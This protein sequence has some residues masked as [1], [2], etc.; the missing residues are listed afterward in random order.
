MNN[1]IQ[2]KR[3]LNTGGALAGAPSSLSG[4]EIAFNEVDNVLYYG[5][6][7]GTVNGNGNPGTI[8]GIAGPGLFVDR[9][10]NQTIGG[11]KTFTNT[12]S[13]LGNVEVD[14]NVDALTLSITGTQIVDSNRKGYFTDLDA[15]GNVTVTGNLTVLGSTTTLDTETQQTSAVT[16]TNAGSTVALTV[17][18]TGNMPVAHFKDDNATALFIDGSSTAPGFVGIGTAA[19]NKKLTVIGAISATDT[20]N[21]NGAAVLN[22]T[23]TVGNTL[24]VAGATTLSTTLSV[25]GITQLDNNTIRTDGTGN[26]T[27]TGNLSGTRNSSNIRN[28]IIDCGGF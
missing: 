20:F 12:V 15:S 8:I 2:L 4:G 10:S 9:T 6:G 11:I 23:L 18:Q 27:L 26:L 7:G 1:I 22:S 14:G 21:A 25:V 24:T 19:P 16:I 5:A 3:R 13:A 28:F 17:N